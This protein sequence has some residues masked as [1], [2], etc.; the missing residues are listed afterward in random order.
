[1][2]KTLHEGLSVPVTCKIRVFGDDSGNDKEK[3]LQYAKMIQD[4]GCQLLTVHGRTIKQK[5]TLTG[6]ADWEIIKTI[7]EELSI[8]VFANGN[9]LYGEDADACIAQTGVAGVMTAEGNLARR[10]S[11]IYINITYM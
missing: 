9:I 5:G 8:P 4:N 6:M 10:P 3:T 2:V 1:M 11:Y 7:Q